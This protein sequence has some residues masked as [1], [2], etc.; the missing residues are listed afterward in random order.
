MCNIFGVSPSGYYSFIQRKPSARESANQKL[1]EKIQVIYSDHKGRYGLPRVY[2]ELKAQGEHCGRHRVARR[3]HDLGLKAK[4]KRRF[5]VTTDSAHDLPVKSNLLARD[6]NAS[7]INQK[8]VGDIT[9]V[10][11]AEGWMYLAVIID[12]YSRAVI[13][14]SLQ[15][16]MTQELVCAALLMA[17][18]RRGFPKGVLVHSDRGSQYCSQAYQALL[19]KHQLQCS[20]SRKG[21]CWDNAVAESFFHTLKI[22]LIYQVTYQTREE[23]KQNIFQYIEIYYNRK[24]RHSSIDYQI[25]Y[26]FENQLY[27][28]A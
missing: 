20:M 7:M 18:W 8:W 21:N 22:E 24:R 9:Y 4:S 3:M 11:T 19:I 5:K 14:W 2:R 16:R 26:T 10:W 17:L 13:G 1:D 12:V 27:K 28:V 23:A 25:P 15:E 6:F